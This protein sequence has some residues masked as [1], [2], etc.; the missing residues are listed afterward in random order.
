MASSWGDDRTTRRSGSKETRARRDEY[1]RLE[2]ETRSLVANI[3][4]VSA[5]LPAG[6]SGATP[7]WLFRSA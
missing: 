5:V 2:D 4:K 3:E 1:D 6:E 7:I